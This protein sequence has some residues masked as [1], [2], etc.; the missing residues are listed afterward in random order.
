LTDFVLHFG[1]SAERC[2]ILDGLLRYRAALHAV[3]LTAG[4]QWVDGSF[5]EQEELLESRPPN[6][7]DVVTFYR[8]APGQTQVS[9]LAKSPALF[10][11]AQV[12]A[13]FHVD[14]YLVDLGA[15]ADRLVGES[16]YWYSVWSHRRNLAW[17]GYVEVG[18]N[19]ADDPAASALLQTLPGPGGKP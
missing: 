11:H 13:S 10:D 4:F 19:S 14:G 9:V 16:T 7:V 8:L 2:A 18:L 5:L 12:K 3:W 15:P 6:D 17:K 1:T